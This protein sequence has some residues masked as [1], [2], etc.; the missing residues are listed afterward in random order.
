MKLTAVYRLPRS[1]DQVFAALTDPEVLCRCIEGC[2][3][4]VSTGDGVYEVRLRIG[5]GSL[6]GTYA[7]RAR[8]EDLQ[9]PGSY[10]LVVEGKAAAGWARGSA[11]MRLVAE[12]A[13]TVLTCDAD[14]QVGG[15]IAAV[16][17]RLIDAAGRRLTDRFFDAL[18]REL[19]R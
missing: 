13:D 4:L 9:P 2:E 3:S 5:L 11:R 16:G 8:L 12:G 19:A 7:G 18:A 14:A 1:P 17:S 15:A 6:K 10:T